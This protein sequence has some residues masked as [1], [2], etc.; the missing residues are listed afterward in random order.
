MHPLVLI[1]ICL[2]IAVAC[3]LL[4]CLQG[5]PL[6]SVWDEIASGLA[7]TAF[8]ILLVEFVLVHPP[9]YRALIKMALP[10]DTTVQLTLGLNA[11]SPVAGVLV[12]VVL[13]G[14]FSWPLV[15]RRNKSCRNGFMIVGR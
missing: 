13:P 1:S 2:T 6:R 9:L 10:G 7:V 11:G 12:W 5:R 4:G 15:S 8:A 14:L 3:L